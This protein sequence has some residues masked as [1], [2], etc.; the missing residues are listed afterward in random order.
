MDKWMSM[1]IIKDLNSITKKYQIVY[2]DPPWKF[3]S[4][5]FQDGGREFDKLEFNHYSSMTVD[6]LAKLP[7]QQIIAENSVCFLWTVDSHMKEAIHLLEQWGFVYKTIAFNWIKTTKNDKK[8][9]NFSPW[10]LKSWEL[11]LLGVRGKMGHYKQ[12]NNV[13]GLVEAERFQHSRKPE[14]VRKRIEQLFGDLEK[15][16]LFA[17][18]ISL[19]WDVW[20]NEIF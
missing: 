8:C 13:K 14:E 5:K 1:G 4:K 3:S 20:G 7:I 6:E 15:I 9:Y 16:E 12:L 2:A 19:G 17:R 18:K 11:V 10:T